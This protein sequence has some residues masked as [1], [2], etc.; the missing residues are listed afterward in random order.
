MTDPLQQGRG[1]IRTQSA[2]LSEQL[3][4][5]AAVAAL[6]PAQGF[7]ERIALRA[8]AAQC[9]QART[10]FRILRI[11]APCA[12]VRSRGGIERSV[13]LLL[14]GDFQVGLRG[15]RVALLRRFHR[16]AGIE[17]ASNRQEHGADHGANSLRKPDR[18]ARASP[19]R[20]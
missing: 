6:H 10:R 9:E 5:A 1:G 13:A 17:A 12:A 19:C 11:G 15:D 3:D 4:R 14:L 20:W 2:D 7:A 16:R 8:T 18:E